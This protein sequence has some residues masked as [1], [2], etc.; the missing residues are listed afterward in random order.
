MLHHAARLFRRLVGVS[1]EVEGAEHLAKDRHCILV[2]NHASYIDGIVLAEVL[3]RP[4]GFVAKA[5]LLSAFV[6]RLFLRAI[7]GEFVERFDS[8]AGAEDAERLAELV[9]GGKSLMFFAEGTFQDRPGL[10]PFRMGAFVSAARAGIPVI[11][12]AI[13][14]TRSILLGRTWHPRH[15]RI[16]VSIG[17]PI[18]PDGTSWGDAVMLRDKA[19]QAILKHLDEP[20]IEH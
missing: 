11:P 14:G 1:L 5:E 3:P 2:A 19:R 6:P 8:K 20:D 17:A 7:G 16:Q 4:F 10:M 18:E 15:G 9:A 13:N 12:V